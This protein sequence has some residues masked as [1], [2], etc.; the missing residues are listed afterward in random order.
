MTIQQLRSLVAVVTH[1]GFRAAARAL[2]VSQ[3]GLTKN[4]SSLEEEYAVNLIERTAKG[5]SLSAQGEA[6][7]HFAKAILQETDRAEHWL[8]NLSKN[9]STSVSLG[10]SIEPSMHFAPVVLQDF[11]KTLPNVMIRLTEGVALDLLAALRENR[12]E[13]A[14]TKLPRL[15]DSSDLRV[16]R[17]YQAEPV[18]VGR[19]GHPCS[20]GASIRELIKYDW[21]VVGD[22]SYQGVESDDSTW[23][24]FDKEGAGRPRFGAVCNSILSLVSVL[25][26]SDSLARVPRSVVEHPLVKGKLVQIPV[27]IPS[28][29][30]WIA[31]V[32]KESR[33]LSPEAQTLS[34][35]LAS[36]ARISKAMARAE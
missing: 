21:A 12:I 10:V 25:I 36:Y 9:L 29:P 19:A 1:G 2:D 8:Q 26:D 34:A 31:V 16:Q 14:V 32:S 4:I 3:G 13:L 23:E 6:F 15:F 11:R 30:Y 28:Y 33:R 20:Q 22:T 5:I 7:L 27:S 18:I 17:L 24:L 35:M